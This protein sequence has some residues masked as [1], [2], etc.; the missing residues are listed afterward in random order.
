MMMVLSIL[1]VLQLAIASATMYAAKNKD[2]YVVVHTIYIAVVVVVRT[3]TNFVMAMED[4]LQTQI[5]PFQAN[6]CFL[7]S[8]QLP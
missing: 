5:K 3:T 8:L 6:L 4:C 7:N 2:C 1:L